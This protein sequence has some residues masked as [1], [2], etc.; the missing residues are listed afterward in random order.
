MGRDTVRGSPRVRN[1]LGLDLGGGDTNTNS[2][3]T[4]S[5]HVL[6]LLFFFGSAVRHVES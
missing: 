5:L 3:Q 1:L 2:L 6:A 4:H